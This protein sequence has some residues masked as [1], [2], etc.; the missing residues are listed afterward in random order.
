MLENCR[1]NKCYLVAAIVVSLLKA[2]MWLETLPLCDAISLRLTYVGL[3][4]A[5]AVLVLTVVSSVN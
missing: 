5:A 4:L 3:G 2:A 1:V